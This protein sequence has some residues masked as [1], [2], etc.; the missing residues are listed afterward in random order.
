[1]LL[2]IPKHKSRLNS[3][4]RRSIKNNEKDI[5][6]IVLCLCVLYSFSMKRGIL[7]GIEENSKVDSTP[8]C[9][10]RSMN[11][12]CQKMLPPYIEEAKIGS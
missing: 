8:A 4:C 2:W 9:A 12:F 7:L 11:K 1:M 5:T 3:Y 10:T 6:N